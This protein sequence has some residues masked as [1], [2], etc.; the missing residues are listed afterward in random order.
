[1][2]IDRGDRAGATADRADARL[3]R[4]PRARAGP[5]AQHARG[6][7]LR[8]PAVRAVP[9]PPRRRSARGRSP[10]RPDRVH[11]GAR[12]RA[13]RASR[14]SRRRRSSARSPACGR[15]TA[16][17]AASRSSTTIRPPSCGRRALAAG[18]RRCSAATRCRA[19]SSSRAG[20]RRPR[21]ATARCWRRCTRADCGRRRRSRSSC[22][23]ST[24]RRGSCAPA[25]RAPRSGSSRSGARRSRRCGPTSSAAGRSS[26]G[27]ATSHSVFVNLR[28]GGLSRQG[29]YKIVQR[30][31]RTAGLERRMSP[32]TL[33]HTFATHLLAGGCDLRSL[34]EMLGHAD[35]GTTQIYTHLSAGPS[36]RRLLRRAS[37]GPD[38]RAGRR[39][40]G[41]GITHFDEASDE[42]AELGHLQGRWTYARGRG[43][44]A[45]TVGVD[46]IQ[47]QDGG[48]STP[49]HEHGREEEIFYVLAGH[50]NLVADGGTAEIGAGRLH[51]LPRRTP[52][53]TRC[54]ASTGSTCSR[55]GPRSRT[56]ARGSRA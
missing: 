22:P 20:T 27:C 17:C 48:W 51:R 9:R 10:A 34:Q 5:V 45:S 30:H 16:T 55:S 28:G 52:A 1:M 35:I 13:A 54:T 37:A 19:C 44:I 3:P 12:R 53:P 7:P 49:A 6:L 4:V 32:H 39:V 11:L 43:R 23:I 41:V 8:P 18:C 29:L 21:C 56:R 24:S 36:A 14:R 25:G 38:R 47:V 42:Q 46:R 40:P 50:G 31:A 2:A 15:S 26:S 33:R